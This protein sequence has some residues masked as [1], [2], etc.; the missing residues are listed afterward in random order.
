MK[1]DYT[2]GTE[3]GT[4]RYEE[5]YPALNYTGLNRYNLILIQDH[6]QIK[7]T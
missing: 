4:G 3:M 1:G 2:P 6:Y 7:E 5:L